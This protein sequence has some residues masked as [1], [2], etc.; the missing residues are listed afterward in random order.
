MKKN[1]FFIE[2][3]DKLCLTLHSLKKGFSSVG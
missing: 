1:A 2:K 3:N